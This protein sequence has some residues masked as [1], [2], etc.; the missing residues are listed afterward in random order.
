MKNFFWDV[1]IKDL[2]MET[3][4]DL[5]KHMYRFTK[6]KNEMELDWINFV[7]DYRYE[8]NKI[9]HELHDH[10]EDE[11]VELTPTNKYSIHLINEKFYEYNTVLET[12]VY[13]GNRGQF[14]KIYKKNEENPHKPILL[15]DMHIDVSQEYTQEQFVNKC[16]N[17][18]IVKEYLESLP[19]KKK[20]ETMKELE[21]RLNMIFTSK[22]DGG[23]VTRILDV[24]HFIDQET[25]NELL[26]KAKLNVYKNYLISKKVILP[27][28]KHKKYS[29]DV[30]KFLA[31]LSKE[32][33]YCKKQLAK[34]AQKQQKELEKARQLMNK[35]NRKKR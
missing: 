20:N 5:L 28:T 12:R 10:V 29:T 21:K 30:E 7:K 15:L 11:I 25:M 3:I 27:E 2:D 17:F 6:D 32:M 34:E 26:E 24:E 33:E 16:C 23:L 35:K 9:E 19:N 1:Y 18:V 22:W 31:N 4:E 13:H 14:I 8:W